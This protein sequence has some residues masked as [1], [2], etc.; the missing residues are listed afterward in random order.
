[1]AVSGTRA[2]AVPERSLAF[3]LLSS[4]RPGQWTKN[5][6]VFAALLFGRRLFDT[7]AVGD[8]AVG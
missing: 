7:A 1:M 5:L 4:L 3:N 8:A 6:L 2:T